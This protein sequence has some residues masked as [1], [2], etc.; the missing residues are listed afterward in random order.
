MIHL[1]AIWLNNGSDRS[2]LRERRAALEENRR[3][4][5]SELVTGLTEAVQIAKREARLIQKQN[6]IQTG[7]P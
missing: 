5:F 6:Y 4:I 2:R 1:R 7:G 3:R